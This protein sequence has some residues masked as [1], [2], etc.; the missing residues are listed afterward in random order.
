MARRI[1]MLLCA[2]LL[3]ASAGAQGRRTAPNII[4]ITV[5]TL[6]ADRLGCYG[7]KTVATPAMDR[8]AADGVVF[9]R[10]LAQVPLT[11]PSHAAILTGTYPSYTGVQDFTSP[12]LGS[13]FRTLAQSLSA[14]GY[15]TG[16][17]VSSFVLD[18]SWGV[19]RGF[20]FYDDAFSGTSFFEKDPALVERPA[21]ES[22]DR[23]I[24]WLARTR[25]RPFF[26]W[27]HLYDPHSPYR[28]P[29]PFRSQ[30]KE[31]PY[32]GEV[33]YADHEVGRLLEWLKSRHLYAG[34][35]IVLLSDHGESL[36]EHGEQ[37]HGFFIY[38][39]TTHVPLIVKPPA[40]GGMRPSRRGDPVETIAVA[41]T[42]LEMAS[43]RDPIQKQ[44][45]AEG[46]FAKQRDRESAAA[47]SETFYPFSSFGWNPLR[48]LESGRYHYIEA[49]KIELYDLIADP[50]EK[51]NL[52]G[53]QPAVA[54][55]LKEKLR[56][57]LAR[58]PSP[59][60]VA[61][62]PGLSPETI[63]K[64]RAL[65]YVAYRSP[66]SAEQLAKGL[67]DPKDK[68]EEF[69]AILQATDAL[70]AGDLEKGEALLLKAQQQDPGMYLLPYLLGQAASRRKDW[71]AAAAAFSR[72][73]ELNPNFDQAMT[74]LARAL[75]LSGDP[76]GGKKWLEKAL[77][78]NPQNLHAWYELAWLH[79]RTGE[80]EAAQAA[81]EK[82]LA[83]QPNFGP[84][85]R[86]LGMI[87]LRRQNYAEAAA[88]LE[89]ASE[90]GI[91]DAPLYNFLGIAYSRLGRMQ[92]AVGSYRKALAADPNLAEAH[93]NLAYAYQRL[94]RRV[95][96]KTE[97]EAACRLEKNLCQ[98][99]PGNRQ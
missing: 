41:P 8:L 59:Q 4:L 45:Q 62:N 82:T 75:A 68:L 29:E 5:D 21:K 19:A 92:Q 64:L 94:G 44:F 42:L 69:N 87:H 22:V 60:K 11:F 34:A 7:S 89:R 74:A 78:V 99:V 12:P 50:A 35:L 40:S 3:S 13:E 81:L 47:Y 61:A 9:E 71:K 98:Y 49:P 79:S 20:D 18:R 65:G 55:V 36:G 52:A 95:E 15:A 80:T 16:A 39:S 2:L 70:Q 93:L 97:Y 6:R 24:A 83:I 14:N 10:A 31:T 1:A 25:Q 26:L 66:V 54:A 56:G 32:D 86:D 85:Q 37:E 28:P 88:R 63:E 17:V 46:L 43:L 73:L 33:A 77:E 23:A 90:L 72:T 58:N 38:N 96:A 27:L 57:L 30:Y 48:G 51:H 76:G 84:A 53:E 91:Q 67:P